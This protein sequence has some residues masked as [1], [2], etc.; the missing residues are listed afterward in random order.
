MP[1]SNTFSSGVSGAGPTLHAASARATIL[2]GTLTAGTLDISAAIT[3]WWFRDVAASRVLQ[4][5]AGGL[6]GR[7]DAVAGGGWTAALGLFLH[8][9]IM[10][11]I[12]TLFYMTSRS[13]PFLNGRRWWLAGMAYGIAVYLVMTY[14]VVAH[15]ALAPLRPQPLSALV[16]GL[17]VHMACV[18]LPIAFITRRFSGTAPS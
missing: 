2:W 7:E 11:V 5:I 6:M 4:S 3:T 14:V 9:A 10:S 16:Q 18:G 12:V 8:F 13:L 17:L 15:S 1:V